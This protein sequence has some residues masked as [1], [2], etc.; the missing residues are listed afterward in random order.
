MEKGREMLCQSLIWRKQHQIDRLLNTWQTP[1]VL[2]HYFPG[3]WH[4][5][6]DGALQ[7][8]DRFYIEH[9]SGNTHNPFLNLR[10]AD[11]PQEAI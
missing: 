9:R 6:D 5:Y 10:F 11:G 4:G 3:G 1:D 7:M 2:N 8:S